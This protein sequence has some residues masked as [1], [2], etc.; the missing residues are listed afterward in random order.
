MAGS[1]NHL[2]V[3]LLTCL[4]VILMVGWNT[5]MGPLHVISL[6]ELVWV[7]SQHCGFIPRKHPK[8]P[9]KTDESSVT[10]YDFA[11]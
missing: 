1:W 2:E 5:Y 4:M 3:S 11:F 8:H 7:S 9:K 10:F 6:M